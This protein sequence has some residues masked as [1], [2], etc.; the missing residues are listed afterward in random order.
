MLVTAT[1]TSITYEFWTDDGRKLDSLTVPKK[2][3]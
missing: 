1:A 3:N 2:C